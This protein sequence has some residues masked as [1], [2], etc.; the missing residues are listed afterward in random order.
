AYL[1]VRRMTRFRNARDTPI[2]VVEHDPVAI[3]SAFSEGRRHRQVD[4]DAVLVLDE[5][6]AVRL[7]LAVDEELAVAIEDRREGG[8]ARIDRW[9]PLA[10][11]SVVGHADPRVDVGERVSVPAPDAATH[12]DDADPVV[13][14]RE[15]DHAPQHVRLRCELGR[16]GAQ[17]RLVHRGSGS[18]PPPASRYRSGFSWKMRLHASRS[19]A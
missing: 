14:L 2:R 19:N 7:A 4:L 8:E 10:P 12:D 18:T 9:Q 5:G 13:R 11:V 6:T 16:Q 15:R 17:P 3:G 1:L